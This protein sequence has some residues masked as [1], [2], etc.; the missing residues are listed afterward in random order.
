M[1][2]GSLQAA[3]VA[4]ETGGKLIA[5]GN[6][7]ELSPAFVQQWAH[8]MNAG[9]AIPELPYRVGKVGPPEPAG[10]VRSGA[11]WAAGACSARPTRS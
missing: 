9:V 5:V 7:R 4:G 6:A 11:T 3:Q 2:E 8:F 10:D 1:P